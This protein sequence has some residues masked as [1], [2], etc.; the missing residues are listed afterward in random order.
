MSVI[1]D[2]LKDLEARKAPEREEGGAANRS[3][4]APEDPNF[5]RQHKRLVLPVMLVLVMGVVVGASMFSKYEVSKYDGPADVVA[6]SESP[7]TRLET[8]SPLAASGHAG[9]V[10]APPAFVSDRGTEAPSFGSESGESSRPAKHPGDDITA[11]ENNTDKQDVTNKPAGKKAEQ[12]ERFTPDKQV[13]AA[14]AQALESKP[15]RPETPS[16][17][18]STASANTP[19]RHAITDQNNAQAKVR[20]A[21][22]PLRAPHSQEPRVAHNKA[23]SHSEVKQTNTSAHLV[24]TPL[25]KDQAQAE[26][27]Q[28]MIK[29]GRE[30]DAIRA[31]YQ[32]IEANEQ[33]DYSRVVLASTLM[34]QEREIELRDLLNTVTPASLPELRQLKARW[35]VTQGQLAM[36]VHSLKTDAPEL[37][38]NEAYFALLASYQQQLGQFEQSVDTYSALLERDSSVPEWWVGMAIGL[39]RLSR[40]QNAALA[41]RQALTLPNLKPALVQFAQQRYQQLASVGLQSATVDTNTVDTNIAT[42]QT[43]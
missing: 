1:N 18:T 12:V 23:K 33:D 36:A 32:F 9:D 25:A 15:K 42:E 14:N 5:W 2:M 16:K 31:L 39:D 24:L 43:R 26:Q 29:Q 40:Y 41:Y 20:S 35:Y 13:I 10:D 11:A 38:G 17:T 21:P 27:A 8:S 28:A 37:S 6:N 7:V 22:E 30:R 4:I 3:L 34:L 19:E